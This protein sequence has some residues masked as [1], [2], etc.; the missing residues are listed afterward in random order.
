MDA[1]TVRD[2]LAAVRDRIA[3]ACLHAGRGPGEVQLVA[4]TKRID[5]DLVTAAVAAGQTVLAENRIQDA[6][7]RQEELAARLRRHDLDPAAVVWHFV[8]HLQ[9][10]KATKATGQFALLHGVDSVK[11]AERLDRL[12]G[13]AGLVQPVLLEVNASLEAQKHGLE[14]DTVPETAARV[15]QLGNLDLRGLMTMARFGAEERELH[16]TF[17]RLRELRDAAGAACGCPLPEL[18]MG[19]TGDFEIAVAEGA[20][21]VRI[22]TAIFGP[23]QAP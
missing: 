21:L 15:A 17:A 16:A 13:E 11:L 6:L 14:P 3:T 23:R 19:M 5:L 7:P 20:T 22:G 12:A 2:N 1:T 18:S 9:S 10:N 8:G 4:V